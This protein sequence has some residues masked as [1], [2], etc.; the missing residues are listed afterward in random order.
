M[1]LATM[2]TSTSSATG[3]ESSSCRIS[4]GAERAGTTAAVI[5][6]RVSMGRVAVLRHLRQREQDIAG[7]L[8]V[9]KGDAAIAV[10]EHRR[11]VEERRALG[12]Q[13]GE[14]GVDVVHL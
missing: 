7:R 4:N 2:R 12:L 3:P 11:V 14:R 13:L 6:M 1:P 8:R 10:A 9:D 5:C